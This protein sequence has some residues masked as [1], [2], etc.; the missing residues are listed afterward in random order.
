GFSSGAAAFLEAF[1]GFP[2]EVVRLCVSV[3][4]EDVTDIPDDPKI[5][6]A[7]RPF[8]DD[9]GLESTASLARWYRSL[10]CLLVP[11]KGEGW[12]MHTHE[13]MACARPVI[14]APWGGSADL[15]GAGSPPCG[16]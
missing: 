13:A 16:W 8:V 10:T 9:A 11:S 7:R 14:Y 6:V 4:D 2:P 5:E 1:A 15:I 3:S 12:G